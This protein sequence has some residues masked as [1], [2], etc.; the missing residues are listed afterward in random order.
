MKTTNLFIIINDETLNTVKGAG[1][2]TAKFKTEA[3]ADKAVSGKL[4]SWSVFNMHFI[5]KFINHKVIS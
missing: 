2:K 1:G 4:E 3:D 5:H